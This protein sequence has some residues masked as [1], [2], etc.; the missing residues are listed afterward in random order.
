MGRSFMK[1]R[2]CNCFLDMK[3]DV[4]E[5]A[6]FSLL[7]DQWKRNVF[8]SE[9]EDVKRWASRRE[10][11]IV[12]A[13]PTAVGKT[14]LSIA[15]AKKLNG[16]IISCDS[17]QVYRHCDIGSAKPTVEQRKEIPHHLIDIREI[18][19]KY[20]VCRFYH[21]AKIALR[22]AIC[23][24]KIPIVVGGSSFY[25]HTLVNGPPQGPPSHRL[26]REKLQIY[27]EKYGV[28][29]LY[30]KLRCLDPCY[31]N[32]VTSRD[33]HKIIRALEIIFLTGKRV[34]D[35]PQRFK[36]RSSVE[37]DFH[38]WFI[39]CDKS[40]LYNV[41]EQRCDS[42]VEAGLIDEIV[43]YRDSLMKNSSLSSSIGYKHGLEYLQSERRSEDWQRFLLEFKQ[44][45]KH[46]AKHQ[47]T[48]FRKEPSFCW[49]DV[50]YLSLKQVE[51]IIMSHLEK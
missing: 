35:I 21:D 24:Q 14:A 47:F 37:W 36:E 50:T 1:S 41:I 4:F 8:F 39:Y 45:T 2:S 10:K 27:C 18:E 49:L 13:G 5:S 7:F 29:F 28:D 15:L 6:F 22:S 42:M 51:E 20:D 31:A 43:Q 9:L 17:V 48:W 19:D 44:S 23:R 25:L 46:C 34:S 40:K 12:I 33:H 32:A 11:V 38:C 26:L 3:C 16:E 30:E